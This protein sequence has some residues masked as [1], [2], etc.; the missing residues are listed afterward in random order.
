MQ[1]PI[2]KYPDFTPSAKP[3]QLHIDASATG[4]GGVLEQFVYVI[5]Y[6]SRALSKSEQNYSVI[7]K[8]F[9]P[10]ICFKTVS[11]SSPWTTVYNSHRSCST[12]VAVCPEDGGFTCRVGIGSPGI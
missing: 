3:F 4:I 9:G 6:A 11:A 10:C 2:L 5:A 12:T 7:Q 1:A 8:V